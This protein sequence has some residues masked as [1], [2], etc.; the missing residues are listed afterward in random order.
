MDGLGRWTIIIQ[1][2][3]YDKLSLII[4]DRW[5]VDESGRKDHPLHGL[6]TVVI[7]YR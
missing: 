2:T 6:Q 5:T 7:C 4:Y 1:T 3:D